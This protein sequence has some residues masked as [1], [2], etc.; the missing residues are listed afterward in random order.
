MS[1]RSYIFPRVFSLPIPVRML[2]VLRGEME[3]NHRLKTYL[4]YL[5]VARHCTALHLD[6]RRALILRTCRRE[7]GERTSPATTVHTAVHLS[8][9]TVNIGRDT[10]RQQAVQKG[11]GRQTTHSAQ[12]KKS[13]NLSLTSCSLPTSSRSLRSCRIST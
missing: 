12:L 2:T 3:T 4:S 7:T 10:H 13:L 6:P 9:R 11:H 5:G 1:I 8:L